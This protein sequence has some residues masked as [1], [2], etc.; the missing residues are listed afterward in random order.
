MPR[1]H[2]PH[3]LFICLAWALS[4]SLSAQAITLEQIISRENPRLDVAKAHLAIGRDGFV[5]LSN[6][7][8]ASMG[9]GW[10]MRLSRD[11]KILSS[12]DP[13][14]AP[15]FVTANAAGQIGI[16]NA[17]FTHAVTIRDRN[18]EVLGSNNSFTAEPGYVA[19]AHL[20]AGETDFYAVDQNK[21]RILRVAPDGK[22]VATYN[23]ARE[24]A[25]QG[26]VM[27]FRVHEPSQSFY[28]RV[29]SFNN[30]Y[31]PIR[32]LGFDGKTRWFTAVSAAGG[33][34][35]DEA[36]VLYVTA[37]GETIQ[38][39]DAD[40]KVV[41]EVKLQYG[42]V[43]TRLKGYAPQQ[44]RVYKGEAFLKYNHPTILF[45]R[46]DLAT[47]ALKNV[48]E[49]RHERLAV[50]Y[51]S[52]VWM[53]GSTL[54]FDIEFTSSG[55][56]TAPQWRAWARSVGALNWRELTLQNGKLAVPENFGGLYQIKVT[57]GVLSWQRGAA[58]EYIVQSWIEARRPNSAG[59][60][61]IFTP[62]NRTFYGAGEAIPFT[63]L[64]RGKEGAETP[65]V[66]RLYEEGT[67]RV[68]AEARINVANGK[69]QS[70]S[71]PASLTKG[72]LP[73]AYRIEASAAGLTPVAQYLNIGHGL[74]DAPF[75]TMHYADYGG[76]MNTTWPGDANLWNATDLAAANAE[77]SARNGLNLA[78]ERIAFNPAQSEV[79]IDNALRHRLQND[80]LA[81]A[82]EKAVVASPFLQTLAAYGANGTR[83]MDILLGNDAGLPIGTG[84]SALP[85]EQLTKKIVETTR[86]LAP[87]PAFRGWSWAAN[88]WIFNHRG[89][90]AAPT[91]EDKAAY[92][93][94]VKR[95]YETG[96]WDPIIDRIAAIRWKMA[97]DATAQFN[98]ILRE[99]DPKLKTAVAAP[100]RSGEA[101]PPRTFENVDEVDLQAQW[102]QITPPYYAAHD[103]EYYKRPGKPAWGHP[104]VW[105]DAGTGEQIM[106]TWFQMLM[107]GAT[108]IGYANH[109]LNWQPEDARSSE[110]GAMSTVRAMNN[111]LRQYGPWLTSLQSDDRVAI[112]ISSRMLKLDSWDLTHYWSV[113][114]AFFSCLHA[115]HP[116]SIVFAEDLKPDSLKKYSAIILADYKVAPEPALQ[117]AIENAHA[118]G[119]K[120]FYD[121][122]SRAELFKEYSP[123][124]IAFDKVGQDPGMGVGGDESA[125][126]RLPK[127][128]Q[129]NLPALQKA[130][131]GVAPAPAR[132]DN[133][134]VWISERA[135]SAGR[136]LFVVNNSTPAMDPDHL[137]RMTLYSATRV[138]VQAKVEL[139]Q[140]APAIYD[141]FAM[142]P[143]ALQNKTFT[144]DLRTLP[145]RIYTML[146][147]AISSV[148]LRGP[149]TLSAGQSFAW[150]AQVR[151]GSGKPIATTVPLRVRLLASD[152][153]VLQ[154]RFLASPAGGVRGEF[155][156]P[157]NAPA[158]AQ[159]LE[160]T[161]LFSGKSVRLSIAVKPALTP[162]LTR[163][164]P[165]EGHPAASGRGD[166]GE[167]IIAANASGQPAASIIRP[168]ADEFGA[169]ARDMI[170]LD[171]GRVAVINAMNWDD[172]LY[173]IDTDTGKVLWCEK[174]GQYFAF[175]PQAIGNRFVVQ[176]FDF[177]APEGYEFYLAD[178]AGK[179]ARRFALYGLPTR[180]PFRMY[181]QAMHGR[182]NNFAAAPDG[183][184]FASSGSLGVA[185]WNRDG[186]LLWSQDDWK[187]PRT[188]ARANPHST[189]DSTRSTA[190]AL[191]APDASTLLLATHETLE[192]RRANDGAKLWSASLSQPG[193]IQRIRAS[194]DGKIVALLSESQGGSL[195]VVRDGKLD[196]TLPVKG[197]YDFELSPD[198][199]TLAVLSN[200]LLKIYDARG[201]LRWIFPGD[202]RLR[203]A[204]FTSDGARLAV[205]SDLGTLTVLNQNGEVLH[206]RDVRAVAV[207]QWL[208]NGDLL[209]ANWSGEVLRL[210]DKYRA[211]WSTHLQP[212]HT[213]TRTSLLADDATPTA[214]IIGW[215]NAEKE[216][217]PIA[218]NLLAQS[219]VQMT[220]PN[221]EKYFG[222]KN[223]WKPLVDGKPDAPLAP[224]FFPGEINQWAGLRFFNPIT[225]IFKKPVRATAITF[226]E[227]PRHPN[228]W[229]RD[230]DLE[231][232][233][234]Q[235]NKWVFLQP[236]LSDSATH[237][238]K[239]AQPVESTQ[240]RIILPFGLYGNL[241]LGEIV[242]HGET[243]P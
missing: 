14:P 188:E 221:I 103:A 70:F 104:E 237:T 240:F 133:D 59:T 30:V 95:A 154:E 61:N 135:A 224:W 57:P 232:F 212:V 7:D 239:F 100:Y 33:F 91:P 158:G 89:A 93:A 13:G 39:I 143:V 228:S 150:W 217:W 119:V 149:S 117:A 123:L 127:Y 192:A 101:Y 11:G 38:K 214:R 29:N 24:P 207:P 156:A 79:V 107:R 198:G 213:V 185:V 211:R 200:N 48:A 191:F 137:W 202:D 16:A 203:F 56:R 78:V 63:V 73:R 65:A 201:G 31:M 102:E 83:Q 112:P 110:A 20:E 53:A 235:Q 157:W 167:G 71:L 189:W 176:G 32:K 171:G 35:V 196:C 12:G 238:H 164:P 162:S 43:A 215:G 120:V 40:G 68:L 218:P 182:E 116:A 3:C 37:N 141:V 49:A 92:Q 36:G 108:G 144:A 236:L 22:L 15:M 219:D 52:D 96:Q 140:P 25:E 9:P 223:N 97:P 132:V 148:A 60:L 10:M 128:M 55:S 75:L 54:P 153:G 177:D 47:G 204:R 205:T 173:G 193:Q 165:P 159:V 187:N 115:H 166:G 45:L 113:F 178:A 199:S 51:P 146:P 19:P 67:E 168:A 184:W 125:Y 194:H 26:V 175:A 210:D 2:F 216:P 5:Y 233:D 152:G 225:M 86:A 4:T 151:D 226:F 106:A 81:V 46:F 23:F 180:A 99:I 17:H 136:F 243:L 50:S 1:L 42:E 134:E 80:P 6:L 34:D 82:P 139:T 181:P 27:D 28:A 88:W 227:D 44:L 18:L 172:N 242:L 8:P 77:R 208:P 126:T 94:A 21:D 186:K 87:Y 190:P 160:A 155:T 129:Q 69:P 58:P 142:K 163:H 109:F 130:L 206:Q 229:L 41:G 90:D 145:G 66:L 209:L 131:D 195:F 231:Y 85:M 121:G 114:E 84:Y 138:P 74:D 220:F 230:A 62:E 161:E 72:L 111:L 170:L 234:A 147:A 76:A 174:L 64:L 222:D 122:S 241:R 124:G 197:T 105:N 118:A 179:A 169:R 183:A 98:K